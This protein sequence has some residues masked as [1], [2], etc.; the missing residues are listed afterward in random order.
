[1][2]FEKKVEAGH[3]WLIPVILAIQEAV[4]PWFKVSPGK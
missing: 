4:G 1:M 3:R 2:K